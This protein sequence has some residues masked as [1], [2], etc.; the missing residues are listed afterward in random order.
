MPTDGLLLL[1]PVRVGREAALAATLNRFGND[2]RGF[3]LPE[4]TP[5]IRFPASRTIHFARLALIDDPD[6]GPGRRRLLLATDFDGPRGDH[7]REVAGLTHRPEAIWGECEGFDDLDRF[8]D[9]A[10]RHEVR[11]DAY[12]VA[13]RDTGLEAIR[14]ARSL[15]RQFH[16]RL[17]DPAAAESLRAYPDLRDWVLGLRAIVR[18]LAAPVVAA[19]GVAGAAW[20]I[21]RGMRRH[22]VGPMLSAAKR[23]NATLDRVWWI[24]ILNRLMANRPRSRPHPFSQADPHRRRDATPPG[25]P[26]EDAVLQNQ[27]TL[28]TEVQPETR[29]T[30]RAVLVLIDVFARHLS[31]AGSL[32]GIS[33]IH[34]VRWALLDGGRRL[35]MASNYDG[36]WEN[37]IDEF[38]EMILS[39]LDALWMSAPDYP[40]AGAQ[41]VEALKQFLRRHQAPANVF[42]SAYPSAT[43]LNL[44]DDLEF[45]RWLGPVVR[46]LIQAQRKMP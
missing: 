28:V 38:A 46:R 2:V 21:A 23:I 45:G 33:T 31:P 10:A 27:L 35:L 41:D 11:P 29:E 17:A 32:V 4:D 8:S 3:R 18:G 44:I 36:T 1:A 43:V 24:R 9:F 6:R 14:D 19:Q 37:Y 16:E 30:L 5:R 13:F 15:R 20:D 22:G 7:L 25:Y 39:G 26:P 12:Y 42:Y 40:Q 34:T